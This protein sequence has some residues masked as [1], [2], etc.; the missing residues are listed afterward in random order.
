MKLAEAL[1]IRADIQKRIAQ[2]SS[3]LISNA[4]VQEGEE[5]SEN[6]QEL[7]NELD[8]CVCSLEEIVARI[9]LTNCIA[10]DENGNSITQLIA[11]KDALTL[12]INSL[13][14]FLTA[15]SEKIDRFSVKEI[16]ILST[17]NVRE[18]QKNVD[19]LSKEL[20][21]TD[22][23]IQNLNWTVELV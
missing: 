22:M 11:K 19:A 14:S 3:R 8:D 7:L 6:P 17:V 12:K 23:R 1:N 15:A 13:R 20:R 5:P 10:K 21:E 2:L 16:K 4:K 18:M 9:N